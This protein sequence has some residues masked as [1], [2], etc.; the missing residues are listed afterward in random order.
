MHS[1]P[2]HRPS[3]S[4]LRN[5]FARAISMLPAVLLAL[6]PVTA[7]LLALAAGNTRVA[8]ESAARL[9][10]LA[11]QDADARLVATVRSLAQALGELASS[12]PESSR[13]ELL[14]RAITP[15]RYGDGPWDYVFL[16]RGTVHIHTPG[17]EGATGV[18]FGNATDARG[19]T[20]VRE[21]QSRAVLGGG[22]T[23]W[24]ALLSDGSTESRRV[25]S[26]VIP[27]TDYWLGAWTAPAS[28]AE[29]R[30]TARRAT[31][32]DADHAA[33]RAALWGIVAGI[34][35]ALLLH[36]L[37]TARNRLSM[38]GRKADDRRA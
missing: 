9:E 26:L 31:L 17:M 1:L 30:E 21:M 8:N 14:V 11:L 33:H 2:S 13:E 7:M 12:T 36:R 19:A 18:D 24:L 4:T 32:A 10:R 6:L 28:L 34:P 29:E 5:L 27:G 15:V 23:E 35:A 16:S 20:F 38:E 25:F 3:A 37:L 22:F